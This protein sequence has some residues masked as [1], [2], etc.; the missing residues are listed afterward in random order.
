MSNSVCVLINSCQKYN[1]LAVASCRLIGRYASDLKWPVYF[2]SAGLTDTQ[3]GDIFECG[4][5]YMEQSASENADFIESRLHALR[6]LQA[7]YSYV[8]LLQD[9]FFLDRTPQY[10]AM[11]KTVTMM[12]ANPEIVCTRLMPCPGPTGPV[13]LS[14]W[15]EIEVGPYCY[16]SFQA[17]IWSTKWLIKFF[18]GVVRKS[19]GLFAKWPQYSRNQ[20]WILVNPCETE[21][22]TDVAVELGGRFVG[23]PRAGKWSNAVYLSPWPYRP[24]A[25][26]KGNVQ[27]W[28]SE[29]LKRE[30][31]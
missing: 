27:A 13:W 14:S 23:W 20:V 5:T 8:L 18:E 1:T 26:E 21:L 10:E 2:A 9:D 15:R 30:G 19:E 29:M 25:V 7:K 11:E 28:A 17:A 22:G 12:T 6:L 31:L 3:K 16:F 24:T 4:F